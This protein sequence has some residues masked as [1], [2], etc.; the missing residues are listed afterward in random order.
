MGNI[1]LDLDAPIISGASLGGLTI[2][3][4]ITKLRDLLIPMSYK[5]DFSC[6]SPGRFAL[7]TM[8]YQLFGG[9]LKIDVDVR[10]G[11]VEQLLAGEGY[12]GSLLDTFSIGM[13][14]RDAMI[15]EPNLYYNE[16][17][18]TIEFEGIPGVGMDVPV[19]DPF[20]HEVPDMI[21]SAI[22]VFVPEMVS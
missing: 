2:P 5:S 15:L 4:H 19:Y 10:N 18:S 8:R 7:F 13:T 22:Y 14:V 3:I 1:A 21:I 12:R 11:N 16:A 9:A 20:P 6:G 17:L